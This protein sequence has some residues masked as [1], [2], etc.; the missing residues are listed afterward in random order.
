MLNRRD[1]SARPRSWPC[2]C[3]EDNPAFKHE[4]L[5]PE[6]M[7]RGPDTIACELL[8]LVWS[9][10]SIVVVLSELFPVICALP[11][12]Q[13]HQCHLA[14]RGTGPRIVHERNSSTYLGTSGAPCH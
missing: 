14:E 7:T 3:G 5:N 9:G 2:E 11:V 10:S 1:G 12:S 6:F 13:T 4:S 8:I